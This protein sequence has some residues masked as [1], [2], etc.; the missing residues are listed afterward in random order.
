MRGLCA[1]RLRLRTMFG[2]CSRGWRRGCLGRG[3]RLCPSWRKNGGRGF[4]SLWGFFVYGGGGRGTGGYTIL[5]CLARWGR[6]E[7]VLWRSW[8]P[9]QFGRLVGSEV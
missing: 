9:C 4:V 2:P 5:S 8:P 7:W 6:D 1:R 3:C